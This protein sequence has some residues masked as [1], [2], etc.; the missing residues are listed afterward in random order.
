MTED[1]LSIVH[2]Y[3]FAFFVGVV[4]LLC[5]SS[6][7]FTYVYIDVFCKHWEVYP[8]AEYF[9]GVDYISEM[10]GMFLTLSWS[11]VTKIWV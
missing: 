10:P 9:V 3:I 5:D 8:L 4:L 11:V 1:L 2:R 6:L 7:L